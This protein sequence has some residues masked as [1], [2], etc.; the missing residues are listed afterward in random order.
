MGKKR[1]SIREK[2]NWNTKEER[3]KKILLLYKNQIPQV[4]IAD[5]LDISV[6]IVAKVIK[7][8]GVEV[9]PDSESKLWKPKKVVIYH[10]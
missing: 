1:F 8:A 7:N 9:D 5:Y 2:K 4:D 10:I 3:N 6:D